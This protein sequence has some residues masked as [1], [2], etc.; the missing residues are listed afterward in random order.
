M[1]QESGNSQNP[2]LMFAIHFYVLPV[3]G[4]RENLYEC[5]RIRRAWTQIKDSL[6]IYMFSKVSGQRRLLLPACYFIIG[7]SIDT[8]V[9]KW[10]SKSLFPPPRQNTE[11][12]QRREC[13]SVNNVF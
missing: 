7:K 12:V 8:K 13:C 1:G 6:E 2:G 10:P 4:L 3:S 5:V 9:D 11:T